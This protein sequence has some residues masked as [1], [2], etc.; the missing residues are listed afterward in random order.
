MKLS[1][2][3]QAEAF[4][5]DL[6]EEARLFLP[7]RK[8]ENGISEEEL[9][10]RHYLSGNEHRAEL[11]R[12]GIKLGGFSYTCEEHDEENALLHKKLVKRAAKNCI[13]GLLSN[14]T[15]KKP[16]WG[17]LTGVRPTKLM[18]DSI[19]SL[20]KEGAERLFSEEF[21]VSEAKI[22]FLNRIY[23]VQKP[24]LASIE[25]DSLDLYI[26]IPICVSKCAY[27]TFPSV[28]TTKDGSLEEKYTEALLRQIEAAEGIIAKRKLRSIYIGGGTPTALR[29]KELGRVLSALSKYSG[30]CEFTVEAGR[31][32]TIDEEKL[33]LIKKA[34][35][36]RISV[37]A[38]TTHDATLKRIGRAHSAEDFFR[39]FE[40]AKGFGFESINCDLIV[41][42]PGED[43]KIFNRSLSDVFGLG[44]DNITIH[45]L[46]IK[47][48]S[49]FAE[50]N[51]GAFISAE[52]AEEMISHARTE[53]YSRGFLPYYMYRQKYMAGNLENAGYSLPGREC[54]YNVD[55]MEEAA[56]IL[57]LGG[58]G[59]SKRILKSEEKLVRA[60]SVK[61]VYSY[62][63]RTDEMIERNELLFK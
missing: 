61:D 8:I 60:A 32:D 58:G 29:A 48:A 5:G 3:S 57:A 63:E 2:Y 59:I 62:I 39:K 49:K 41:G 50:E 54:I 31:P 11:F 19:A 28:L 14:Y 13:F 6:C 7:V 45:T 26:G 33:E 20:G 10:I 34:G 44:A 37:N 55:I 25:E 35:A 46:A 12:N 9:S 53:L 17:S 36:T 42:L 38:Q 30:N 27:C 18:R 51:A 40:L 56:D 24:I 52:A 1:L 15:G 22:D 21:S 4:W 16:P 43:E 47:R 23:T